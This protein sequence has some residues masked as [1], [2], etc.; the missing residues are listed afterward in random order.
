[1]EISHVAPRHCRFLLR[2]LKVKLDVNLVTLEHM[3][4]STLPRVSFFLYLSKESYFFMK[5][6]TKLARH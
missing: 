1:M 5:M 4:S 2:E 3:P 6:K